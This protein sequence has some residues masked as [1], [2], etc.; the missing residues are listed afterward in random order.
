MEKFPGL[1]GEKENDS[2]MAHGMMVFHLLC[3]GL[4]RI[5]RLKSS[6]LHCVDVK[7]VFILFCTFLKLNSD[8]NCILKHLSVVSDRN[9]SPQPVS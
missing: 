3:A 6:V 4:F 5:L 1:F 2:G 9:T 7:W 8:Y